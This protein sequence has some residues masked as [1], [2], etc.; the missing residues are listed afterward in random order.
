MIVT[1]RFF[2]LAQGHALADFVAFERRTHE[3][4]AR[5]ASRQRRRSIGIHAVEGF[6]R[7]A[8]AELAVTDAA[9]VQAAGVIE[10]AAPV[11][12]DVAQVLAERAEFVEGAESVQLEMLVASPNLQHPVPID[13]SIVRIAFAS[14]APGATLAQLADFARA[15]TGRYSEFMAQI[16]WYNA[17]VYRVEGLNGFQFAE[18]DIVRAESPKA[19]RARDKAHPAPKD[20]QAI[21]EEGRQFFGPAR[22]LCWLTPVA[23]TPET[24]PPFRLLPAHA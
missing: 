6:E 14:L 24:A 16:G 21:Y 20:V 22:Q 8:Y 17:G 11:P 15:S 2:N 18:V 1:V 4:V 10:H 3:A 23:L 19:A 13:D 7:F 9:T 12:A 5:A